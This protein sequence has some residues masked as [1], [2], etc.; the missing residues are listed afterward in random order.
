MTANS[1]DKR[2][3][4]DVAVFERLDKTGV[5]KASNRPLNRRR[6]DIHVVL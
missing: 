1:T 4:S 2:V 6:K 5:G 3:E